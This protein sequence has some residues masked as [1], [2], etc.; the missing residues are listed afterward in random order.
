MTSS[1][2]PTKPPTA[3]PA[4]AEFGDLLTGA[5]RLKPWQANLVA[6]AATAATFALRVALDGQLGGQPT[7]VIFTLPIMLSA[8][9]GGLR[10][11]LLATVVSY[12]GASYYLLP[13][14]N[15]FAVASS[16]ERW[17]QVLVALAGVCISGLSE[18]LHRARR[19]AEIATREQQRAESA[20]QASE[21][22]F[23]S[24]FAHAAVGMALVARDGRYLKVNRALC[25]MFGYTEAELQALTFHELTFAEDREDHG[26]VSQLLAGE[27]ESFQMEKRYRH[28]QGHLVTGLLSVSLV[29][30]EAGQP[31]HQ[32]AQIQDISARKAHEAEIARLSRLYAALSQINQAIVWTSSRDELFRKI[33]QVLVVHGGFRMA[34]IGWHDLEDSRL[35][36]VAAFGDEG[37]F[38][39]GLRIYGDDRA[40]GGAPTGTAF[41]ESRTYI[42]NDILHDPST[43]A[44]R[45]EAE[46]RG[47]RAA[48]SFPIREQEVTRGTITVYADDVGIFRDKEVALFEEAAF[49]LSFALD[50]LQREAKRREAESANVRALQ[51]LTEAQRIG[52]IGDWEFDLGTGEV[53]WSPQTFEIMGRDPALGPPRN[54]EENATLYEPASA[55]LMA[56]KVAALIATGDVQEYELV[57]L[58]TDGQRVSV[59]AIAV[60]RKDDAGRVLGLYGTVQDITHRKTAERLVRESE[61]RLGF[62]MEAAGIGDWDMNLRT[63]V[64]R[65]SLRHDQC[66]GYVEMLPQWGY[67]TFLAHVDAADRQRVDAGFQKAMAGQGSYDEE[68]RAPWPDGSVHW[69]WT[70]GR[71]YFDEVGEPYRVAGIVIDISERRKV[72]EAAYRLAAIVASSDDAIVGKDLSGTI[73]SWNDGAERVFG[74]TAPEMI[75]TSILRLIPS[76]RHREET[77]IMETVKRGDA[78]RSLETVRQRKDGRLI[79]VSVTTS[80]VKDAAGRV[81]GASKIARDITEQ[82]K[83]AE[84]LQRSE[85]SLANAQRIARIGS[86]D[87]EIETG[88]LSWSAE[89]YNIFGVTPNEFGANY[90]AFMAAVHPEDRGRVN[91]AQRAALANEARL[92]VEHRIVRPDGTERVVHELADLTFDAAERPAHLAGTVQDITERV[93]AEAAMQ[94]SEK[95]FRQLVEMIHDL[96]WSVDTEG[97]ITYMSPAS[98]RIYGREPE[99]MIGRLFTD[100]VPADDA[101]T[102]IDHLTRSVANG[103]SVMV[104][105]NRVFHRDGHEVVLSANAVV[106]RDAEGRIVGTTGTSRDISEQK[107]A[108]K[109]ISRLNA[110]L[111]QR[112]IERTRELHESEQRLAVAIVAARAG[113][114]DFDIAIGELNWSPAL[115]RIFDLDPAT[116]EASMENWRSLVHPE[117]VVQAEERMAAA[118]TNHTRLE[119][120]YRIV[121]RSGEVRWV[122]V[123]GDTSYAEDGEPQRMAG[124]CLD[125]T[126]RK[127]AELDLRTLAAE[128]R[129]ANLELEAYSSAVSKDLRVAEA[130]DRIKSAFLATMSHELRTPLNSIIGFTGIVLMGK[131]GPLNAEQNKQLEMVR[132]SARHLLALINDVLDLSKI[133]AGQIE[134]RAQPFHLPASIE[135]VLAMI[136]PLA[137]KKGLLL[138]SEVTPALGEMVSDQR[139][140]EQILI[141]LL[142]NAVKFTD[143]GHVRL[144]AELLEDFQ[145]SSGGTPQRAVRIRVA[146][147]GI[148]ILPE[149]MLVLFQ[150]FRQIDSGPTRRV[151]GTGLGLA[152]SRRLATLLGGDVTAASTW[153]H[154]SEFTVI[155]P[156]QT[157]ASP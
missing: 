81:I 7:L 11:G 64:A 47:F 59:H 84:R 17:Q 108:E 136:S 119:N 39:A 45:A 148:G 143:R 135:R 55:A 106:V 152:I 5:G 58:R 60:P 41:R 96:V 111:E 50:N 123:L 98:R 23:A 137:E 94:E 79:D 105:E 102:G 118:I 20:R 65:R 87:L 103:N 100:F 2:T 4:R 19:R 14:I 110:E 120:E 57:A 142:S 82:K 53:A 156:L 134:M 28:R 144:T 129:A 145:G 21:E 109:K 141:N 101:R 42:C 1:S 99:E 78:L 97:R 67:E 15:S 130:A 157:P 140:V 77:L 16:V 48:A 26:R 139:R 40:E 37:D 153:S 12:L 114:W 34:W 76:D 61:E 85:T 117:D 116:A 91:A 56:E 32:I 90:E 121:L 25:Q 18:L 138:A 33:C 3:R 71:F 27:I 113:V 150:P 70:K 154:G 35:V 24:S 80:P 62:A 127:R 38:L 128:L 132:E 74:Y 51:R 115:F 122:S 112:V 86:W 69:L 126:E 49:D 146:D 30:D 13:P 54:L 125:I 83:A 8:Y 73:T 9:L 44:W 149:D 151:D 63:N 147:T 93:Q 22:Q 52:Q 133:E 131:A 75:G 92:D 31:L 10:A 36:P 68:F 89:I 95:K 6:V 29:R 155:L 124:V 107:E 72:E 66:F 88:V 46:R 43:M 104:V